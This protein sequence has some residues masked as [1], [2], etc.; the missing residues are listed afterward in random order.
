M[1]LLLG[2]NC[3]ALGDKMYV[4]GEKKESEMNPRVLK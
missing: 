3:K 4:G 2:Q 1:I